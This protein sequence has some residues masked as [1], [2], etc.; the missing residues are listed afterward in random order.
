MP[1][2][3]RAQNLRRGELLF[4]R[5]KFFESHEALEEAWKKTQGP[6][7][8]L[9]QGFI[10]SAAAFHKLKL[11]SPEGAIK[12][13]KRSLIK[14]ERGDSTPLANFTRRIGQCLKDIEAGVFDWKTVPRMEL[15][16]M[17]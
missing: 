3:S 13:L 1:E 10:Q 4:N 17:I 14:L 7:K 9:L 12:L 15:K 11:G 8:L 16:R 6:K 2:R 5:Q